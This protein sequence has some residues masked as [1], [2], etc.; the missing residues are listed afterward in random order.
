MPDH[1]LP[2]AAYAE[3][4]KPAGVA[5]VRRAVAS[6]SAIAVA[7]LTPN[8]VGQLRM[9]NT[10]LFPI[11]Y[12]NQVYEQVLEEDMRPVCKLGLFN[13]I[14][15]G[16]VC[17]RVEDGRDSA[18]CKVYIMTLGILAPYRRLGVA[19]ALLKQVLDHAAP[20]MQFAGRRVEAVYLHV[21]VGNE[22]AR[23]FYEKAGF[24]VVGT[25]ENYYNKLEPSSAWVLEKKE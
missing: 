8:N 14:P 1:P 21:Q 4:A 5:P 10:K 17:C 3:R 12:S 16:N 2:P 18:H 15:V 20:G 13:D 9:L 25:A 7:D 6:R 19:S 22:N 24:A 23:A 11:P